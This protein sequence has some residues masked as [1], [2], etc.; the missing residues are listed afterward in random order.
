MKR[1][2]TMN[3]E[4]EDPKRKKRKYFDY[5]LKLVDKMFISRLL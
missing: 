3:C 4:N 1:G 2:G 5:S